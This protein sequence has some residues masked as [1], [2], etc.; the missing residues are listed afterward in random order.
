MLDCDWHLGGTGMGLIGRDDPVDTIADKIE[1]LRGD[2]I[3][4]V[5]IDQSELSLHIAVTR[6]QWIRA[7]HQ[8]ESKSSWTVFLPDGWWIT[9][10]DEQLVLQ[11]GIE[12]L[13]DRAV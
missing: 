3:A 11:R 9:L 6:G 8:A 10:E 13:H 5:G 7:F 2:Q 12:T 1:L 4:S